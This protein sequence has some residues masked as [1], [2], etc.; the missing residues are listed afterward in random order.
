MGQSIIPSGSDFGV[1]QGAHGTYGTARAVST[2]LF[3]TS[4]ANIGQLH[5]G[6]EFRIR[7]GYSNYDIADADV[8]VPEGATITG[9]RMSGAL[10]ADNS[11][12]N[13]VI[14]L[15]NYDWTA[16]LDAGTRQADYSGALAAAVSESVTLRS[17]A[18]IAVDTVYESGE[19]PEAW[20]NLAGVSSIIL[21]SA[22]DIASSNPGTSSA[23][24]VT[25]YAP[26][27][28]TDAYR[29]KLIIDWEE[30]GGGGH[31]YQLLKRARRLSFAG[32]RRVRGILRPPG[33]GK[34]GLAF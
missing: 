6:S 11:T 7:R 17:T 13:F 24:H 15:A 25:F 16:P 22:E 34:L 26:N 18:G 8:A 33:Y 19:L 4:L 1:I 3:T 20:L 12:T 14:E 27:A 28:A 31:G 9:L 29:P 5:N 21:I 23:E 32:W 2:T 10:Q 30:A